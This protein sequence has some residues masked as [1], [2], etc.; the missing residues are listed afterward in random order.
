MVSISP[1]STV[2]GRSRQVNGVAVEVGGM[3]EAVG[4][5]RGLGV[6]VEGMAEGMGVT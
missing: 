2:G 5:G 1:L 3:R 4:E 6:G